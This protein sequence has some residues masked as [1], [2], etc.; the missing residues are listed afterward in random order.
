MKFLICGLG[1]I[2]QRHI[3]NLFKLGENDIIAFRTTRKEPHWHFGK[4]DIPFY[5]DLDEALNEKPDA[6]FITNPTSLHVPFA[7]KSAQ[8]GCH[9]FIEKPVSSNLLGIDRLKRII[10]EKHLISAVG[11]NMRF[12]PGLI[13]IKK[14][15]ERNFLGKVYFIK[16]NYSSF[17]PEWH[18]WDNYKN[19]YSARADLGGGIILT[20]IHELDYPYWFFGDVDKVKSVINNFSYLG[21]NVDEEA[22]ILLQFKS[23]VNAVI[24]MDF[25]SKQKSRNCEITGERGK[26]SWD[27]LLRSLNYYPNS[28][29]ENIDLLKKIN[30]EEDPNQMYLAEIIDFIDSIKL[31]K[32]PKVTLDDGEQ[33]LKIALEAKNNAK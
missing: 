21:T 2:G 15:L 17:L 1:S 14:L 18:P 30:W 31:K 28:S 6:V 23:G 27:Y 8:R 32:S 16:V 5:F 4:F 11:C 12:N 3:S 29:D 19:R 22:E 33:V 7:I 26:I 24:H 9:L 25:I 13:E 20:M 10:K